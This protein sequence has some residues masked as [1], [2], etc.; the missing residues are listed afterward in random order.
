MRV[1]NEDGYFVGRLNA[2]RDA[3]QIRRLMGAPNAQAV[4]D[5]GGD[6]VGIKL[7]SFADDRGHAGERHGSSTVTTERVRNDVGQLLGTHQTRQHKR[8]CESWGHL[9]IGRHTKADPVK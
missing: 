9:A 3:E 4:R 6:L 1:F 7:L 5:H 2:S 8:S